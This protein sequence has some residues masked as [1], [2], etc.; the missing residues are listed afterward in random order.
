MPF[1][2]GTRLGPYEILSLRGAGGMGEVYRSRDVRLDRT[3]ALKVLRSHVAPDGDSRRRFEREAR[4]V[5][6]LSHPH[7]CALYDVGE[8]PNPHDEGGEPVP[9]LVMEYLEGDSLEET[10]RRKAMSLDQ[11]LRI[12]IQIA[13]A[14]DKAHRKGIVHRDL[15]PGNIMLT[16][17]GAKLLDFGLAKTRP[18]FVTR[19]S[20]MDATVSGPLT[21][22]G[23]VLGTPNYMAPEQVDGQ[24]ADHRSDLFSFGAILYEMTTG[25]RAFEGNSAASVMAA[26]LEREP[27]AMLQ[28]QPLAP[29]L[30]DHLVTRCLA[31][32]PDERWQ[33]AGDVKHELTW[34]AGAGAQM[35]TSEKRDTRG[36][37]RE[38]IIW[39]SALSVLAAFAAFAVVWARRPAPDVPVRRLDI[40]TPPTFDFLSLAISPDGRK[41]VFVANTDGRPQLWLRSL[42]AAS[43]QPLKNTD[44]PQLPFWSPDSRS[45]GFAASGQLKRIDL[46]GGG[47]RKL[48]NAPLFLGG[49]WNTDGS[50][51]FVPNSN[52][53]VFRVSDAEGDPVA[54]TPPVQPRNAHHFPTMLPDGRHFLFYVAAEPGT[55]GVY[56]AD[57]G[58]AAPRRLL[59]ADAA[60]LYAPSGHLLFVR[61]STLLAQ[62]FD[63]GRRELDG[64]PFTVVDQI[65][66][67]G[68]AG[69]TIVGASASVAGPIVYRTGVSMSTVRFALTWFDR[70]GNV[71][72]RITEGPRFML[73]PSLSPDERRLTMFAEGDLWLFDLEAHNP[74][75][76]TFDPAV[77][78]SGIWSPDGKQIAFCSNRTGVFDLY[79]KN[80]SGAGGDELLLATPEQKAP[81]DWSADGKFILYRSLDRKTSFDIWALSMADRKPFP[82]VK[83]DHEERDAQF[84]PDGKWIA[85]QSNESGRFEIWVRPFPLPGS[86]VKADERWQFSTAGGTEVRWARDGT[87]IFYTT[88]DGR[89]MAVPVHVERDGHA[90]IPGPAVPLFA[91]PVPLAFG[92]GTALPWYMVSRDGKRFLMTTQPTPLTTVPI[93]VLLNWQP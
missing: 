71:V 33:S 44:N 17:D 82:I 31:K 70:A 60:A 12:A 35:G 24:D 20:A 8:A 93:T 13:D 21:A 77:D 75:K 40:T 83:T 50:I 48:A 54:V 10:L 42:D 67:G 37:L 14:L 6:A 27:P 84:S 74:Q 57:L 64:S 88:L 56:L 73:N 30:L 90:V 39:A 25:K 9:F 86:A 47:V 1:S 36:R 23:T 85:Y 43:A 87:E 4:A 28:L 69:A 61:G 46:E 51:L 34:I 41:V 7:I 81:T 5:A 72:K 91:S 45:I 92:A 76:F 3:V 53:S 65:A 89:L 63:P 55:R 49:T 22:R 66:T 18:A 62:R 68:F 11:M 15:K 19:T 79:R 32:D 59:D 2:Q 26:I 16:A 58:G 29:P 78:F 80:V 52:S 38:R